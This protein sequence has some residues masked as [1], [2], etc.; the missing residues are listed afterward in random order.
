MISDRRKDSPLES[1]EMHLDDVSR[2]ELLDKC[3]IK[4]IGGDV[5]DHPFAPKETDNG[6][7]HDGQ[8]RHLQD[9]RDWER[10]CANGIDQHQFVYALRM[11][12]GKRG[13]DG[14]TCR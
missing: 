2:L 3:A 8:G 4:E 9:W 11:K 14:S 7:A 10:L 13:S 1:L 5:L 6:L 12:R